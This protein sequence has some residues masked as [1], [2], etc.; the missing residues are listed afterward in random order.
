MS[1]RWRRVLDVA[2]AAMS[3]AG[4]ITD[5]LTR[6][7]SHPP[8]TAVIVLSVGASA[9]LI[10]R[11]RAPIAGLV[12]VWIGLIVCVLLV[13]PYDAA[14]AVAMVPLYGVA[15]S[16]GRRRSLAA[17]VVGA[18]VL[19]SLSS[20]NEGSLLN[21]T[22]AVRALLCLGAVVVGDLVRARRELTATQRAQARSEQT[23]REQQARRRA[24]AERLLI[25][26][27]LHDTL[28]HALVAINVRSGVAALIGDGEDAVGA[29][30]EIKGVSA[31]AL[32]DLRTTLD[33]LRDR[34]A[35]AP[36][37]P[38]LDLAAVPQL[39]QTA[40]SAGLHAEADVQLNGTRIPVAVG[41][42]GYRIVQESLTN[43][44]RHAR[45]SRTTVALAAGDGALRITVTDDGAAAPTSASEPDGH[46][47]QGM[48]ER[49]GALGG[50]LTAGPLPGRGWR[51]QAELPLGHRS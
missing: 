27:E 16:G 8:V 36:T 28:A 22:A 43:V 46:G 19:A 1:E 11:R 41:Q 6:L 45:A 35:P 7:G 50:V 5:A 42:A 30:E 15:V 23:E 26:R 48:L 9:P 18:I 4:L 47:I 39:L 14:T 13:H 17:G 33:V 12:L 51:V 37:G 29:L 24:T 34:D 49:A 20:I 44:L 3:T 40:R 10:I 25:A 32:R 38:I 31:D 21:A 2:L